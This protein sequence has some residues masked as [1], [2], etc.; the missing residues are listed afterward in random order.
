MIF[1]AGLGTR[2]GELGARRPKPMLPICG[3]PLI[4]WAA[5]WLRS[6]GVREVVINLHHMGEQIE[7]ELGDGAALGMA[8][9]Y[10]REAAILG[11]GGGLRQ[12]RAL[13]DDGSG[14]PIVAMNGKILL[15]LDLAAVL[16]FHRGRGAEATMVLRPD[17]QPSGWELLTIDARA[18]VL[19]LLGESRAGEA[20][21]PPLMFTGV[22]VFEPRF[23]DRIPAEGAPCVART[24]YK[25]LLREGG[26]FG[27][28][29]TQ[30][31][32]W[33][34]STAGRYLAGLCNVLDGAAE[35]AYAERPL[36]GIDRSAKIDPS[37]VI[38]PPV[39]IGRDVEVGAGA[40]V[41]PYVELGDGVVVAPGISLTRV[42][43]WPGAHVSA[44][45]AE[46]VLAE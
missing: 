23:L 44:S 9:A 41:G 31:Y 29:V 32:W 3:A 17:P 28:F 26:A 7:A 4:R 2:L 21:G 8:I 30:R 46:A 10:S 13:L 20:A 24:A 14:A 39:W 11:T 42:S 6:Q 45:A 37:A 25:A 27:G 15:D 19:S 43:A 35:L 38:V 36:R 5:L 18:E 34:H 22:H 16:A 12:A 33:E 1:A 40:R